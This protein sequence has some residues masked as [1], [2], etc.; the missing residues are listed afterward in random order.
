[1]PR[2][3]QRLKEKG[4]SVGKHQKVQAPGAPK[5]DAKAQIIKMLR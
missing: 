2:K 4:I 1:M 5:K 3:C